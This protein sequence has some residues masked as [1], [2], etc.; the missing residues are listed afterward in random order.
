MRTIGPPLIGGLAGICLGFLAGIVLVWIKG[1]AFGCSDGDPIAAF[2]YGCILACVGLVS[3]PLL[4][5]RWWPRERLRGPDL[6]HADEPA[7][8]AAR[9]S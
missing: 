5:W 3:G 8:P 9:T 7:G 1:M 6:E 4:A 2:L